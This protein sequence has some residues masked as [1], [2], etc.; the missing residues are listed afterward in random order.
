MKRFNL[1]FM[2]GRLVDSEKK[3]RIQF[4]PAYN[5]AKEIKIAHNLGFQFM[6]WT[7]DDDNLSKHH[8]AP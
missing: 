4:F 3:G 2:Q 6:E 1:G 5:W 8:Y 7:I